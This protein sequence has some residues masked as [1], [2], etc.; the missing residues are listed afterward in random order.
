MYVRPGKITM[1]ILPP[2][3]PQGHTIN[4]LK[5]EVYDI[6]AAYYLANEK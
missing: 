3:Y 5:Q 4:S 1:N 6:M 2:V